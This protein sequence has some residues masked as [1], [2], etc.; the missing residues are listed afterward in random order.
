MAISTNVRYRCV[1]GTRC[2]NRVKTRQLRS[3][4]DFGSGYSH[5]ISKEYLDIDVCMVGYWNHGCEWTNPNSSDYMT[6]G[7]DR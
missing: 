2:I 5:Y 6:D 1:S 7:F 3:C 4:N